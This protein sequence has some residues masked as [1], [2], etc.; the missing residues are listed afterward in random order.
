MGFRQLNCLWVDLFSLPSELHSSVLHFICFG[1]FWC[2]FR[3]WCFLGLK[4]LDFAIVSKQLGFSQIK[5]FFGWYGIEILEF[6]AF[7]CIDFNLNCLVWCINVISV[8]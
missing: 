7:H 5:L 3:Q 6:E 4:D 2:S 8:V 1:C